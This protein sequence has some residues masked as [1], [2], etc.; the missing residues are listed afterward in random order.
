[1]SSKSDIEWTEHTWNPTTG[2]SKVSPGCRFCYAE[3]MA[4][5][6]Q[7]IGTAGYENGFEL[8]I[9]PQRLQQPL[10]RKKATMFFVNSMSDL[11]H[12]QIPFDFIDEVFSVIQ[13]TQQHT[14]Q[15]L[16]KRSARMRD[17]FK[18][19]VVPENAWLGVT[20]ENIKHGK[21]RITDLREI[22]AKVLFLSCE[23][24]LEDLG[25]LNLPGIHW[26]IA[27]GESG[28]HARPMRQDWVESIRN[29]C[30]KSGT[31]FFFKQ[32][33]VWGA[34]GKRR[35]KKSNGRLLGGRVW[36]EYPTVTSNAQL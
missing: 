24:L 7:A 35:N 6:L 14:Y 23:P 10:L 29:Q 26:V 8:T 33:G 36:D 31:A 22:D 32:W 19:R 27:G 9:L 13:Q 5:R 3:V 15:I 21:P 11:F 12:E 18:K 17:Y 1:M 34:D 4:K 25:Q 16:T 2:C 20:V 28:P 30:S